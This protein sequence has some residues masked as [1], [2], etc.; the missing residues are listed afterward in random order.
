M[1]TLR[2]IAALGG[3]RGARRLAAL[4]LCAL[5]A[6]AAFDGNAARSAR[7]QSPESAPCPWM[8]AAQLSDQRARELLAAMSLADKIAMVHQVYPD[9]FR[10]GAAGWIP[11]NASLCIPDLVLNDAGQGVADFQQGT[12]AFPA[13][14]AQSASWDPALQRDFGR[15][16]GQEAFDKGINVMLGPGVEIDRVPTNG[17]NWE[18]MSE[19]PYVAGRAGAAIVAGIQSIPVIAT[20]KHYIANSQEA[21][22][23]TDSAD[24]DERTLQE[25]YAAPYEAAVRAAHPGSVM[26]SYNRVD[27]V[28]ACENPTTLGILKDQFGFSG[29]VMSDW[30]A[31]HSTV[32]AANAGLD[33][34]MNAGPG[35]FFGSAL[36]TAVQDGQVPAA[37]LD[38]MVLRIVRAMFA[39]GI[40]DHP[41]AAQ[42][43]AWAANVSTPEHVALARKISEQGTVLLK[44]DGGILPLVGQ[45]KRIALIGPAAG[46]VGAELSYNGG[47]SGHV[48]L[49]GAN[50]VVSPLQGIAQRGQATGDLVTFADGSAMADAIAAAKAA[51]VAVVFAN[52]AESEGVDRPS[53]TLGNGFFCPLVGC[54]GGTV[55]QDQLIS[56]VAAANPNTVVV[57][58][59]GGPVLMPWL[60]R[61]KG[62]L[63]AWYPG[64]EDGNAIAALL[65]G[66][67]NPSAKLPETFPRAAQDLP[68]TDP[69]QYPGVNDR[70]GVP[71]STYSEGLLV[72]YRWYDARNI[73]PLFPFG[74]GLSYT[75]FD[76]R[77]LNATPSRGGTAL[78]TIGIDI[79]NTGS[80]SGADVPQLYIA[81][82]A[83]TGEPPK[84]LEGYAK[85]SLDP[86]QTQRV[87]FPIDERSLSYWNTRAHAW[88][89][90]PGCY[91]VMIGH[92]SRDIA[93]RGTLAVAGASCPGAMAAVLSTAGL[94]T[95]GSRCVL[96]S[97]ISFH[98]HQNN[99]RV[100]RVHVYVDGRLN[101][102]ARGRRISDVS[103]AAPGRP[104]F[105]VRIVAD[106]TRHRRVV[107]LRRY[108]GCLKG[109]SFTLVRRLASRHRTR[110]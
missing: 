18:Y 93:L 60:G 79:S 67:V 56:Q 94:S 49:G 80:R 89:V 78:A 87:S 13:P 65:F 77:N 37:R 83:S 62:L 52:D 3:A 42:P 99:G 57:L 53:L 110:D 54:V 64:L 71:H 8:N 5:A 22:R 108:E 11:A 63:Q 91:R 109:S 66:D 2:P 81:D 7:A 100:T 10:Y 31:T 73:T 101:K 74:F 28:Y 68:T 43:A 96:A 1:R 47:G 76:Y 90:A 102:T 30:G 85:V 44:N 21:N 17:R 14:I 32:P 33:M 41:A 38:D 104:R 70:A 61:V 95:A 27:A 51:D 98:L 97:P 35:T 82:P 59:T 36:Q 4:M 29:F 20:L 75:T 86:G 46:Q 103:I 26:C 105:T 24:L 39:V 23:N 107:S 84:Q 25:L 50:P 72:G 55:D 45:A 9:G 19:D 69:K 88:A 106:T 15:A 6:T 16:L 58:D 48:P 34:E 12:T 92:S 40:F